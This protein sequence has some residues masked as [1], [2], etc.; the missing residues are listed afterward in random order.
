MITLPNGLRLIMRP[1]M[2]A[3]SVTAHVFIGT[4]ARHEDMS[5]EYG[6]SH[7]LEHLLFKGSE[8]YPTPNSVSEAIEGVGGYQ[9]AYTSHELTTFFT[10]LPKDSLSTAID[11]LSDSV[12]RPLFDQE[13]IDRERGVIIE[14]MNIYKD[15]PAQHVFDYVG[16][17][18]WP[19]STLRSNILG[20]EDIIRS[21]PR[22]IIRGYHAA[23][24]TPDNV[25]VSVAGNFDTDQLYGMVQDK[26]GDWQGRHSRTSENSI[27]NLSSDRSHVYHRETSQAHLVLAA[28][29]VPYRHQDEAPLRLLA[30]ILGGGPSS[31]LY[32]ELREKR[33]LAYSTFMRAVGYVDTGEWEIYV[34]A[35]TEYL[36]EATK[37]IMAILSD[38]RQHGVREEEL[39]RMKRQLHGRVIMGQETNGAVADRMGS[40]LLLTGRIRTFD[41]ILQSIDSVTLEDVWRVAQR[42]LD[43]AHIRMSLI[44]NVSAVEREQLE[45]IIQSTDSFEAL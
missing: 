42:Y 45:S 9:N 14:E 41:E 29:A 1:M 7:F 17:V 38:V 26:F 32:Q 40:E 44:A 15:D 36:S 3:D 2:D 24:Y 34:G 5:S 8:K 19:Q 13:E 16:E 10:K 11:V 37:L 4:G 18:I 25:V 31:R 20:T 28:R 22:E 35:N 6:V 23:T 12:R 39:I 21:L 30:A 33:G 43:P 27:G